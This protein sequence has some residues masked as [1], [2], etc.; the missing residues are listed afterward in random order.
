MRELLRTNDA[1][2]LSLAEAALGAAGIGCYVAD[3][4]ISI[5]EGSLGIFPRRLLV[6]DEDWPAARRELIA[7]GVAPQDLVPP[8]AGP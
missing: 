3:R 1:V 7:A 8:G 5:V 4:N 6:A 2:L